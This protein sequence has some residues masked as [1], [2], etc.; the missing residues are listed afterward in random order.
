MPPYLVI[1]QLGDCSDLHDDDG[2]VQVGLDLMLGDGDV[3][4]SVVTNRSF[5]MLERRNQGHSDGPSGF[6]VTLGYALAL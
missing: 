2:A 5:A 6:V 4:E 3:V 1:H